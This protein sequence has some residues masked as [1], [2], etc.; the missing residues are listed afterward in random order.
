[1]SD[2]TASDFL[3]VI[4]AILLPPVAVL[5][6]RGCGPD[7]IINIILTLLFHF[8]GIIH[9]LWIVLHDRD[10][11]RNAVAARLSQLGPQV[12]YGPG[13][14]PES[15]PAAYKDVPVQ[16]Q[17]QQQQQPAP[18]PQQPMA[19]PPEYQNERPEFANKVREEGP[20]DEKAALAGKY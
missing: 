8:P 14:I 17:Q 9:A 10:R 15:G 7:V 4:I 6:R 5:I 1:M 16:Q 11:R 18:A 20:V 19:P 3:I 13:P 2:S 12:Y